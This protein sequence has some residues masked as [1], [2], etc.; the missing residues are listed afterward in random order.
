MN[1]LRSILAFSVWT[2]CSLVPGGI[3]AQACY[4]DKIP[5]DTPTERFVLNGD[6]TVSDRLTGLMWKRCSEGQSGDD[7][8]GE[9]AATYDWQTALEH[10]RTL[11]QADGFAGRRDW[12]LPNIQELRSIVEGQCVDPAVN[13]EVFPATPSDYYWT[14]SPA[15]GDGR[16]SRFVNFYDGADD[17]GDKPHLKN[18]RLV[19]NASP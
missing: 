12:R 4:P 1:T 7:C 3:R 17:M 11:D 8:G 2:A 15:A 9:Q 18:I 10:V 14:S 5:A 19:R 13:A 6:G 16:L